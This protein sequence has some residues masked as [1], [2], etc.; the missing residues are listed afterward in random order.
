MYNIGWMQ[1]FTIEEALM[2]TRFPDEID[3]AGFFWCYSD[4]TKEEVIGI[5]T[6]DEVR[7]RYSDNAI[8]GKDRRNKIPYLYDSDVV[9]IENAFD[10]DVIDVG[11]ISYVLK[12]VLTYGVVSYYADDEERL[13][14][15]TTTGEVIPLSVF[16]NDLEYI[17]LDEDITR[18]VRSVG[19]VKGNH[20]EWYWD[21]YRN[22]GLTA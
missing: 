12:N 21:R 4:N 11:D 9:I 20:V 22:R 3:F 8:L 1:M 18:R 14:V 19:N 2:L 7:L 5:I 16:S 10:G 15:Y 17:T 13:A 6:E